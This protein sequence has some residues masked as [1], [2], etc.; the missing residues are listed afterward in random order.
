MDRRSFIQKSMAG[1]VAVNLPLPGNSEVNYSKPSGVGITDWNLGTQAD[2][3]LIPLAVKVGLRAIQVSVGTAPDNMPLRENSVRRNYIE[4]GKKQNMVFCSVAAGS[5]LNQIPLATEPQSAVYVIDALEAARALGSKNILTAF[6]GNGNLL[7]RDQDGNYINTSQ[8]KFARY[9]W[10]E[11]DVERVIAVMKQIVPRAEDL[12]V[13]I[14]LENTLSASQ[15]LQIIEEIGSPMVQIYYD[16][17]NSWANG[18]DVPVEIR[19]IGNKNMCEV[20]IKNMGSRLLDDKEG[21]VNM[22][23]CAEALRDIGYDKWF[24]LETSGRPG[25]FEQDTRAN[26]EYTQRVFIR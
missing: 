23:A 6:F 8:G 14:G 22:K 21:Q 9:K 15:N 5:I 19:Q 7:E 4:A 10:K 26:V 13:I 12:G 25:N 1:L 3:S 17:G 2:P 16:I 20:H 18:Y 11:K 24:V